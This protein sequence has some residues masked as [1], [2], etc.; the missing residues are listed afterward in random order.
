[1]SLPWLGFSHRYK[2]IKT[3]MRFL[4]PSDPAVWGRSEKV[5]GGCSADGQ[6]PTATADK[7]L[8]TGFF[9]CWTV[10]QFEPVLWA[11]V[12]P[13]VGNQAAVRNR[14]RA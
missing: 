2:R 4:P 5:A 9:Q 12:Y 14:H 7:V 3:P 8:F 11:L 10:G 6:C 1:M 13:E